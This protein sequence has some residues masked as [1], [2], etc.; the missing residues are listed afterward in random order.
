MDINNMYMIFFLGTGVFFF[1]LVVAVSMILRY[2]RKRA[3]K[4]YEIE[5]IMEP[6][7]RTTAE[8]APSTNKAT[9][10]GKVETIPV[11]V[12]ERSNRTTIERPVQSYIKPKENTQTV[13]PKPRFEIYNSRAV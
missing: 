6:K 1:L 3:K 11:M 2:Q 9:A 5:T 7:Y 12:N 10:S 4:P 8:Y 13:P